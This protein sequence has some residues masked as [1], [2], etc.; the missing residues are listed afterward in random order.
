MKVLIYGAGVIGGQICHA[1]CKAKNDVTVLARGTWAKTLEEEGL[2]IHHYL[3]R[4]DSID[5]PRVIERLDNEYY[6]LVFAVMQYKQMEKILDDLSKVNSS[7]VI[8]TGNNL[9]PETMEERIL[10]K[11]KKEKIVLFAFGSTA[12]TRK[13][14]KLNTVHTGDGELSIGGLQQEASDEVKEVIRSA[15]EKTKMKISWCDNMDSWLKY[16]AA[17]ILPV[18]YLCYKTD[19]DLR[20]ASGEDRKLLFAAARDAYHLL[21]ELGYPVRPAG[22]E[23]TLEPGLMNLAARAVIYLVCHS[24][25][26]ALC[27]SEHCKHAPQEMKDL[28]DAFRKLR[29][30][31]PEYPMPSFD[32]LYGMMPSFEEIMREYPRS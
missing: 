16:H 26:G 13:N 21:M 17:F 5:H 3:Q 30:R 11:T 29:E 22:D 28:H 32:K 12:G 19:C 31:K 14:G 1:L 18:V 9:S 7:I 15:F 6:D 23:K 25:I 8:L 2:C 27:T 10:S 20:K 4:R 24:R